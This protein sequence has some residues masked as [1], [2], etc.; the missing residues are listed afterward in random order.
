MDV[1]PL[2]WLFKF[3]LT[4]RC[5]LFF[6]FILSFFSL[7][8]DVVLPNHASTKIISI[9]RS[10]S[11]KKYR[12]VPSLFLLHSSLH[13]NVLLTKSCKKERKRYLNLWYQM[14]FIKIKCT[15]FLSFHWIL[16]HTLFSRNR[17]DLSTYWFI[18]HSPPMLEL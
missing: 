15:C 7:F 13:H 8:N 6:R 16:R 5:P 10:I 3:F 14:F 2:G 1:L 12:N 17:L 9:Q 4:S 18:F 11:I